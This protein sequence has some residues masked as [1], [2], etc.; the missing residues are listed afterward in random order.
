ME[1]G[2]RIFVVC[3]PLPTTTPISHIGDPKFTR[4][5]R[6]P[7]SRPQASEMEHAREH[8][9]IPLQVTV[10]RAHNLPR[11]KTLLGKKRQYHVTVTYEERTWESRPVRSVAQRVEWNEV[12]DTFTVRP[13]SRITVS[14]YAKKTMARDILVGRQEIVCEPGHEVDIVFGIADG[15]DI[16]SAESNTFTLTITMSAD[17]GPSLTGVVNTQSP[18]AAHL[19]VAEGSATGDLPS[20]IESS[21]PV[22]P[23]RDNPLSDTEMSR[24]T[25][26][27]AEEAVNA[28]KTWNSA[29]NVIKLVMDTVGPIAALNPYASLAWSLLSTIPET[30]LQQVQR[31]GNIQVLL[32]AIRDAFE[33]AVEADTLRNLKPESRQATILGEMLECV[34]ECAKFISSYAEDIKVGK[35][36]LK[37]IVGQVDGKIDQYRTNLVRLRDN[38]LARA[39]VTMR[40][41]TDSERPERMLK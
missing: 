11:L 21:A 37:N 28:I 27:R 29:V 19:P 16:H 38:F 32:E 12:V 18:V 4:S 24:T 13:L 31:D 26:R 10:L 20:P 17:A 36:T 7:C 9:L 1:R 35:R 5:S 8:G 40:P 39:A 23:M 34:S 22:L 15:H 30:L 2:S 14:V 6:F 25:L 3:R 33:F 41:R